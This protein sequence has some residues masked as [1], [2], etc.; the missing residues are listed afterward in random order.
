MG[1][2]ND[3]VLAKIEMLEKEVNNLHRCL[4]KKGVNSKGTKDLFGREFSVPV[5]P[6]P[7][8]TSS[9]RSAAPASSCRRSLPRLTAAG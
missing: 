9:A 6:R 7:A 4:E 3:A 2:K 5:R 8:T 1:D